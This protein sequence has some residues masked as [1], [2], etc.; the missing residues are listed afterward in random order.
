MARPAIRNWEEALTYCEDL[1]LGGYD[2]WRLPNRNELQ[3]L[4][5]YNT[6]SPTIDTVAFP[7]TMSSLYWSYTTYTS[8]T[9]YAWRV[10]FFD[11]HVL[12]S[13]KS[14]SYYLRAVRGG[15]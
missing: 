15:Q 13:K 4:V 12:Y 1:F 3:S 7:D 9:D 5:D 11:G 10:N 6:Y 8:S 2:D 14:E